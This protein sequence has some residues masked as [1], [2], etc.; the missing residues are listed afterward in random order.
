VTV[1]ASALEEVPVVRAQLR[2]TTAD[3]ED[4]GTDD[5]IL[6]SLR[7][8]NYTWLNYGRI[9]DHSEQSGTQLYDG[10]DFERGNTFTYDLNLDGISQVRDIKWIV[11]SKAGDEGWCVR[12]V[13]LLINN[14]QPA[15]SYTF[16]TPRWLDNRTSDY[17]SVI[18]NFTTLRN[19]P[20]WNSTNLR[21]PSLTLTISPQELVS[22]IHSKF[23]H[24]MHGTKAYWAKPIA[25]PVTMKTIN[26]STIEVKVFLHGSASVIP[27]PDV[28]IRFNLVAVCAGNDLKIEAQNISSSVSMQLIVKWFLFFLEDD[29]KAA[30]DNIIGPYAQQLNETISVPRARC[31]SVRAFNDESITIT[32]EPVN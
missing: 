21:S 9:L 2:I 29:I 4:A 1:P 12:K 17:R 6:V 24:A 3:V 32:F 23:G 22:R 14:Q 10:D 5:D 30:I 16:N 28:W 8:N 25:G 15:V 18:I 13:E 27:D 20:L 31:A 11:L 7:E 26:E 19:S